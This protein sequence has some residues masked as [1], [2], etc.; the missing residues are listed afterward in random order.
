MYIIIYYDT[1]CFH[2]YPCISKFIWGL[3]NP[4]S[5]SRPVSKSVASQ[6]S[7]WRCDCNR[8]SVMTTLQKPLQHHPI[9]MMWR[10]VKTQ[11]YCVV[12]TKTSEIYDIYGCSSPENMWTYYDRFW[13]YGQVALGI[14]SNSFAAK[15]SRVGVVA[16]IWSCKSGRIGRDD[17]TR[18]KMRVDLASMGWFLREMPPGNH[19]LF[20]KHQGFGKGLFG[21]SW[22]MSFQICWLVQRKLKHWY[23]CSIELYISMSHV[24]IFGIVYCD[25]HCKETYV[26]T[27]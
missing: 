2:V 22:N 19:V 26:M 18:Q 20:T 16:W 15:P 17:L 13:H 5:K 1:L 11:Q 9:L 25:R 21:H 4:I 12:R 24:S 10:C 3:C 23:S 14:W 27:S 8:N 7:E 6:H